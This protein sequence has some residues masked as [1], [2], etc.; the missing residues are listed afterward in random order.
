MVAATQEML[1]IIGY[2]HRGGHRSPCRLCY[3]EVG[4]YVGYV[5]LCS[6]RRGLCRLCYVIMVCSIRRGLCRI[7]YN[8]MFHR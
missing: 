1:C 4:V 3:N 2:F 8:G 5:M 6:V 7:C